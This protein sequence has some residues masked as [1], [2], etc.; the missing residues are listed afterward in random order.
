MGFTPDPPEPTDEGH[1]SFSPYAKAYAAAVVAV[2][3]YVVNAA[4]T[5]EWASTETIAPAVTIVLAPFIVWL[6]PNR[7]Q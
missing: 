3:M 2:L 4:I 1:L 6:I 5:G 7:P